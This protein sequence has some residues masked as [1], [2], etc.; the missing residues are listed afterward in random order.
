M[1]GA[2]GSLVDLLDDFVRVEFEG[3]MF[4]SVKEYDRYLTLL[5]GDYMTLP[6][7][8]KQEPHIHLSAFEPVK[9]ESN[10]GDV[11]YEFTE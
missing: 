5:Y 2:N 3:S 7:P 8:E 6:P 9:N 11:L 4:M 1:D 10:I